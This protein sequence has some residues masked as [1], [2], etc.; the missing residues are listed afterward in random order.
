MAPKTNSGMRFWEYKIISI[1]IGVPLSHSLEHAVKHSD[2]ALKSRRERKKIRVI[3]LF[4]VPHRF[5]QKELGIPF[6]LL[7]RYITRTNNGPAISS[8]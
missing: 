1:L 8:Q 6:C 3:L 5:I 4:G 2:V 7:I